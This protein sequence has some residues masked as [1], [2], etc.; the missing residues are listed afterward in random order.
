MIYRD[1]Y[2]AGYR[3]FPLWRAKNHKGEAHCECGKPDCSAP[4][5]H[6]RAAN[7]QHTPEWDEEQLDTMEAAGFFATG[8]GVLCKGLLVVDVDA[9]NG[10]VDSLSKLLVDVPEVAGAGLVVNTGSGGGSRHYYF[11]MTDDVAMVSHLPEYPGIDFKSTG[12]VV[13]PGS[14]HASGSTYQVAD[15]CPDDISPA[16]AALVA[17][18]IKPERHRTT[19]DGRSIDVSHS[20]IADMLAAI[21]NDD[22]PYDDWIKIGMAVHQAT[23][24]TGYDLWEAWSEKSAKHDA[25]KMAYRWHT[26]GRNGN[27]VTIGTLFYHA[28]QNGW[29]MPVTFD[30]EPELAMVMEPSTIAPPPAPPPHEGL[31]SGGNGGGS[32]ASGG[33]PFDLAGV[34][35]SAP[36]GFVGDMAKWIESQSRRPRPTIAVAAALTAMGNIAGLRYIDG[37]DRVTSNLFT[38][39]I[40]GSGTGKESMNQAVAEIHRVA[41]LAGATHGSIKSEQEIIR[42]L[43]RHQAAFYVIDEIG[44][45]LSK[46]SRARKSGGAVYLDGVIAV[47]MSAYSKADG[48]MLLT[49][50]A[51]EDIRAQL[52]KELSQYSRK[53]DEGDAA[54]YVAQRIDAITAQLEGLDNG[55]ERPFLSLIGFTTPVT[56]DALVDFENATNGFVG[57]SILFN[58]RDTAPR[59]K[60]GFAK[61]QMPEVMANTIAGIATGNSYDSMA[62]GRV[63][64]YGDRVKIPTEGKADLMLD[65]ALDW[66][67]D[68]AIAHKGQSGLE[69]LYLRAYELMSKV[70]LV[71]AIPEGLRTAEH[72]RWAFALIRR[73]V[74][75]KMR[76]VTANDRAKDSPL[77][78][79]EARIANICAGDDGETLGVICNRIRGRKRDEIERALEKMEGKGMLAKVTRINSSNGK[80]AVAYKF[81]G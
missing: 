65:K 71:L 54:P 25:S 23:G 33:L 56:F 48:Y 60:K 70:S 78:A 31:A 5:K 34:D 20:D 9:R 66:F 53:A 39:C 15:G 80:P 24:G 29:V 74:E 41:G 30:P 55:L 46:I 4:F 44:E 67:E 7:W 49:G 27:P 14:H 63:E 19:Y 72:V 77:L 58:E 37:R 3:I 76:L 10:G 45:M 32:Q 11:A 68:Q 13:G 51:K 64:F 18:L 12:Y 38:F 28:E 57:R 35:L 59:S 43:I 81:S 6:P 52:A 79:L 61:V 36:P 1:F 26:F 16:P 22:C 73:D 21:P 47:L 50:D 62:S 8:Y 17:M 2:D 69:A 42:N 75:E 40:A